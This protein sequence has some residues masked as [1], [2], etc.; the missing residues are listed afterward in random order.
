MVS[1]QNNEE[2][3]L[4]NYNTDRLEQEDVPVTTIPF[5]VSLEELHSGTLK[6][7]AIKVKRRDRV[8]DSYDIHAKLITINVDPRWRE[9]ERVIRENAGDELEN[10][11]YN[12][13][14]FVM[15][16]KRH[17]L[18]T[19][20]GDNLHMKVCISSE[21]AVFGFERHYKLL[22]GRVL[23]IKRTDPLAS[24]NEENRLHG[25]G[26]ANPITG[27]RG[28]LIINFEIML[29]AHYTAKQRQ[30]LTAILD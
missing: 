25:E 21:E 8:T 22:D 13:L 29:A 5:W 11:K 19:R 1:R 28:D 9:G 16:E 18:F 4:N 6:H 26:M 12:T 23:E 27:R 30:Q 3:A 2:R 24:S 15:R 14:V 10:G 7:L 17:H 20:I